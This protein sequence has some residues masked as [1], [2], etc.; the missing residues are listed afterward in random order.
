MHYLRT[1]DDARRAG[2]A[3][4]QTGSVTVVGGGFIGCEVASQLAELRRNAGIELRTGVGVRGRKA[5]GELQLSDGSTV[6]GTT[7]VVGLGVVP[8][9]TWLAGSGVDVAGSVLADETGR[10]ASEGVWALGDLAAWWRPDFDLHKRDGSH[11]TPRR[12]SGLGPEPGPGRP[13]AL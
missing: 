6:D 1:L 12:W 10:T 11:R 5:S 8:D 2:A 7:F 9:V 3:I 4:R 13:G